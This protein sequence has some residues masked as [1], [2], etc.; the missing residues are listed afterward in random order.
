MGGDYSERDSSPVEQRPPIHD[1][2]ELRIGRDLQKKA[3][4]VLVDRVRSVVAD[5]DLCGE[6]RL[7][8]ALGTPFVASKPA[9]IIVPSGDTKKSS[10]PSPRQR[11]YF[12]PS[13]EIVRAGSLFGNGRTTIS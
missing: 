12:P 10:L 4:A 6:Q 1:G 9:A 8:H 3:L 2:D 7:R 5:P 11:G 13:R